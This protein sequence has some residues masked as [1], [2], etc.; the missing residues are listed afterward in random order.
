M[1]GV[2]NQRPGPCPVPGTECNIRVK[3]K[4]QVFGVKGQGQRRIVRVR[5]RVWSEIKA[6]G[7]DSGVR[8][9]CKSYGQCRITGESQGQ[10]SETR[11][12]VMAGI[13]VRDQG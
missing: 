1:S 7:Q 12:R 3:G 2:R 8:D 9:Q 10:V 6:Q 4:V 5:V 13:R 11:V